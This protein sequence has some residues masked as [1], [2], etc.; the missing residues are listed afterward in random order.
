MLCGSKMV[1]TPVQ[2]PPSLSFGIKPGPG[3]CVCVELNVESASFFRTV[4]GFYSC[5]K[6]A[7][8]GR[9]PALECL[10]LKKHS[11]IVLTTAILHILEFHARKFGNI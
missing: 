2:Q 8:A 4:S 5:V 10:L 7:C 6:T 3:G 11:R 1:S 9:Q